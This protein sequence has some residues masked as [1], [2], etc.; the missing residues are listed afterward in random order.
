VLAYLA[1]KQ[2]FLRDAPTIEDVVRDA[3][4]EKLNLNVSEREY[5]SW[6]NSLGNAMSHVLH[7]SLIPED[8]AVAIEYRVNGR[9]YR[10][11]FVIAGLDLNKREALVIVELKQWTEI[12]FS[13]L[14][15]HVKTVLG[16]GLIDTRH[17]SY[18]AWSYKSHLQQFNEY[19]YEN[20]VQVEACAYLHNLKNKAVISD[21]RYEQ[22]LMRAPVFLNGQASEV[23]RLISRHIAEGEGVDLL[24]KVDGARVRP[25]VQLAQ[26]VGSMLQGREEYVLIDNQKTVFEKIL[27][28]AEKSQNGG[29]R[30][31]IVKGGPGTGKSVIA[32]QSVARLIERRLNVKYVS[33][34]AA[35]RDVFISKLKGAIKG[36]I[37]KH[38][39]SGSG[40]F[41]ASNRDSFDALIVDEAHR[42]RM[43]S[44]IYR[45]LGEDQIKE[46]INS[47]RLSVFFI[48]EAQKVT[49]SDVGE[50]SRIKET[51]VQFDAD[52]DILELTSQFR[53]TAADDYMAWLDDSLEIHKNPESYFSPN[54]FEFQVF[55]SPKDLHDAIREKNKEN[56][57]SRVVAGYN[58]NWVSQ[59]KPELMDI[60]IDDYSARWN[61]RSYG[62]EWINH[63]NSIN[64]VGCIHTCQ[65]LEVDYVGVIVGDDLRFS[66]GHLVTN[67]NARAR[68]DQSLKG[69]R[70]ESKVNEKQAY[71]KADSLI[72]NTYR[73][74]MSRGMRGCYVYFTDPALSDYFKKRLSDR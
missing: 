71:E 51:A 42:L 15:E 7:S 54:R 64:E 69:F 50:I 65:G 49:W 34:N 11:D 59:K 45:N 40:S 35:P 46:I 18:Q 23:S 26:A 28:A 12:E 20:S 14:D 29:K 58:W 53:M 62:N 44:G 10:L 37:I 60:V 9:Q 48:D 67:P 61:L 1:T 25:S 33:A 21:S 47:A 68:T 30:V 5:V 63:P 41:T 43:K 4:R 6:R 16:G 56:N 38:L 70:K 24:Q 36:D 8:A 66:N 55:D 27:R 74:L 52:V 57:R 73:I 13:D 19:V 32:I 31:V 2:Q 17:P 72:R 39:F 3:V 22:A